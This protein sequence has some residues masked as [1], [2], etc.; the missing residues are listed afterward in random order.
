M[1]EAAVYAMVYLG[2]ALMVYN[3][4]SY[5]RYARNIRAKGNW[6]KEQSAL[7]VPIVLLVLFLFGYLAVGILGKPDLIV[8]GILFGG[9][10][11]VLVIFQLLQRITYRIQENERLESKL[12]AAE[13]SSRAKSSFLASVS[14]EI[15]TP[16]NAIIGLDAIALKE[17]DLSDRTRDQL[18]KIGVSARHLLTLINDILDMS[19]IESERMVL[20]EE[21]FSLQEVLHQINTMIRE[22]CGDAGLTY[23]YQENGEIGDAYLGD[24]MK[25]KQ[26][27]INLLDNAVKFTPA[28]GTVTFAV[29][30][31]GQ[32]ENKNILRFTV[33]DT[34]IGMYKEFI[35]RIFDVF[36]QEDPTNTNLYGGGGLGMAITKNI[37]DMMQGEITVESQRGIGSV[38]TVTLPLSP[39][40]EKPAE[41]KPQT[42]ETP[43][44]DDTLDLPTDE[45][46]HLLEGLNMLIV[47][48]MDI[49]ADIL[50]E[51]LEMEGA[52]SDWAENGQIAVDMFSQSAPHKY[53]AVLMDLRMP[54]MDGLD[55]TRAIRKLDRPDAKT[56]PII[57]ITANAFEEDVQR[58][59]QAG[60]NA[61]LSKPA[62]TEQLY[63]TLRRYIKK[64][65]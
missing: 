55:A 50:A 35:P 42:P 11:F 8:S 12:M 52:T 45:E 41:E 40:P 24:A 64:T 38:F 4:F 6:D 62:D 58:S 10:I 16:M 25:L 7:N 1:K 49:N 65:K 9:S 39:A 51:L 44:T 47:E 17:P 22:Q 23:N 48:D 37:V 28:P 60:M 63:S 26:V 13:E 33:T 18:E 20:K 3:I 2:S 31:A 5:V 14:H 15:R 36:S 19:R 27:L 32:E 30:R 46:G 21:P 56:V 57:A 59:L 34:G 54:V 61:H 43:D 53:D 29:E